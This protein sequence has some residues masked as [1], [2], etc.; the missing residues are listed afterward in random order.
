MVASS[1]ADWM[2]IDPV[3]VPVRSLVPTQ[4]TRLRWVFEK[5]L[6]PESS[7]CGDPFPHVVMLDGLAFVVDGHHRVAAARLRRRALI[8]CRV[9][10]G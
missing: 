5:L 7:W 2:L 3:Q 9:R 1:T 6:R 8:L 4:R 10:V